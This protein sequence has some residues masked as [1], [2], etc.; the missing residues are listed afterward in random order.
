MNLVPPV[1]DMMFSRRQLISF[2]SSGGVV[3]AFP[4]LATVSLLKKARDRL[5]PGLWCVFHESGF[6]TDILIQPNGLLVK[7]WKGTNEL[8]FFIPDT[9]I[10]DG[11]YT[12]EF[13]TSVYALRNCM[14]RAA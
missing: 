9:K 13:C 11:T 1:L 8:A 12:A 6:Q 3:L 4:A 14:E 10:R 2:L 7:A 5:R